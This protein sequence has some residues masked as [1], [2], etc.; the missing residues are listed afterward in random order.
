LRIRLI[1]AVKASASALLSTPHT[2]KFYFARILTKEKPCL[3][4]IVTYDISTAIFGLNTFILC[5]CLK[6]EPLY[7]RWPSRH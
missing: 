2:F 5:R 7:Y 4:A 1:N 6:S 3:I